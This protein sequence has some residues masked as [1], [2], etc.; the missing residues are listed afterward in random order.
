MNNI[1]NH[2]AIILDGNRR[3]ARKRGLPSSKGHY[4]G[5]KTL[6][7]VATHILKTGTKVLSVFAFST[8]NFKRTKEEVDYLMNLFISSFRKEISF[9]NKNNV[10]VVFSGRKDKLSNEVLKSMEEL[11]NATNENTGGIF[12]ICLNYGG[13]AEIVDTTKKIAQLYK[14]GE[15]SLDE[16]TEENIYKYLYQDLPPIDLMI[17]T[18]GEQRISNFMLY[19]LSY[20]ELIFTEV[21]FPDFD[22]KQYDKALEEYNKRN[23]TKGG[24]SSK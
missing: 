12:N 13:Q 19:S 11:E 20:S 6:K 10:K 18:S 22:E 16:I 3:W 2:V 23:I 21:C 4:Q 7:K 17:R 1:P 15:I 24:N 5:F 8:E 9:F 14:S